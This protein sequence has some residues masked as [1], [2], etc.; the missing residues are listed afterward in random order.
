MKENIAN[1]MIVPDVKPVVF[2]AMLKYLYSDTLPKDFAEVSLD[3]L[4]A[5][6]K[7]GVEKL[8]QKCESGAPINADN[9]VDALIVAEKINSKT[10][11]ER[12]KNI[13]G[14]HFDVLMQSG[15][16]KAELSRNL[17]CELLSHFI[18]V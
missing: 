12:A 17:F 8:K 2:R 10:L 9:V 13:F 16:A 6:D 15:R 7:Y 5:A 1:E 4:V 18:K 14:A 3:L 11:M